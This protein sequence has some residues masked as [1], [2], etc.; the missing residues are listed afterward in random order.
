MLGWPVTDRSDVDRLAAAQREL[1]RRAKSD[2]S[3]FFSSLDASRPEAFREA[4][5]EIVPRLVR[6]YGDIASVAAAEWYESVRPEAWNGR[7]VD[8]FP[9]AGVERGVRYHSGHLFDGE[10]AQ[11]LAGLSGAMQ[12]YITY[13]GRQTIARNVQL[14]PR[15]PRFARVPSGP[16]T[17]AFC[18]MLAS[19][20]F[21]Y[22]SR[23]TAG[24]LSATSDDFH[25]DCDCQIVAQF[26][27]GAA[28]IEG[29]D[30]D[31]L[32]DMYQQAR[33]ASG[34]TSARD[35]AAAMRSMFPDAFKDGHVH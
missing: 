19:R 15:R 9:T 26:D 23:Q 28:H 12:R 18:G 8:S 22:Y 17:C 33:D 4:L 25:D 27:R 10:P 20:G 32:F 6:E 31:G 35:I 1:V 7:T 30:P 11:T 21:V 34:A 13:S 29:Y 5:I 16:E 14:D 2:L 24:E 3:R